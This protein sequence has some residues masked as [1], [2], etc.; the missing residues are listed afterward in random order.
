MR[1]AHLK[2]DAVSWGPDRATRLLHPVSFDLAAGDVLG[3]VGANGAGKSTLL[4]TLYRFHKPRSGSVLLDGQD[5]WR[6]AP[7]DVARKVAAVL[8]E[9]PTDFA[10]SVREIVALG[11]RPHGSG[12]AGGG[13]RDADIVEGALQ[14]M[15]L[16]HLAER[17]FGTL[18]GGEKQ[19]AMVARAL[20]QEPLLLILDE[21]T[22]HLDI[23]HQ[24]EILQLIEGL[25]ITVIASLHDLNMAAQCCDQVLLMHSGHAVAFGAPDRV[26]TEAHIEAAYSVKVARETLLPSNQ[27]HFSFHL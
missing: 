25:N 27:S 19:R 8:Q 6:M 5:I 13:A 18:S 15:A 7:R 11:R 26:L 1:G 9:Q 4:R 10:L 12:F 24:L 3:I 17:G 2:V 23:R 22:N 14:Q 16:G 20:A 21:P